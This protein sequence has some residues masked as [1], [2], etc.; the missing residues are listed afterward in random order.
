MALGGW[1]FIRHRESKRI[2][3]EEYNYKYVGEKMKFLVT[4]MIMISIQI[5]QIIIVYHLMTNN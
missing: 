3:L 4:D 2:L 1:R 5:C